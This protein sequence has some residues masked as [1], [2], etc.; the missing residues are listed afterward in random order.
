MLKNYLKIAW[1]N[2]T[3][4]K[5]FSFINIFGLASGMT[6]CMLAM[7]KV[8]DAYDYDTF[9][10]NSEKSY[11][12]ITNLNRK[13]GEH[14]LCASSPLPLAGYLKNNY[15]AVDKSTS[16]FFSQHEVTIDDKKLSAKEAFVD[17][18]FY[19][20]FGFTLK[21]GSPA[22]KPQTAVVT[23][24]T[25]ARF[26]GKQ[27]PIGH[28]ITIGK[29]VGFIVTGVL[30]KP[31]GPSHLSFDLLA[32]TSSIPLLYQDRANQEWSDEAAAYTYIQ[33]KPTAS[34]TMLQNILKNVSKQV[35]TIIVPSGENFEFDIQAL[36]K[37]S[38]GTIPL[39]N[40]TGE[41][42][43]P[44][45]V[46][47]GLIGFSMLLLAF[48]NYVNLTLARSL[49]RAREVGIRKVAGALKRD[50]I[51]QFLSESVLVAIFA[52]CLAYVQL[53]LIS[54]LPTVNRIIGDAAQDTTL[55]LYFVLFTILTGLFAGWIPAKVLS[56]FQPVRVLKGKFN[57]KLFGGVGLRKTLTVIQFATSLVA[58]VTLV[59]FYRQSIYMATADYGFKRQGILNIELPA[60]TYEKTATAF[61]ALSGVEDVSATSDLPGFSGGDGKFIK[62]GKVGDSLRAAYFAVT[63]SFIKNM[64]IELIA[65]E[66]LPNATSETGTDLVL[67]NEQAVN[68]LKF[69]TPF[70]AVGKR[71]WLNDSTSY[72]V[73]GVV[74]D[75]H[76]ASFKRPI[77]PMLLVSRPNEF[78]TMCLKVAKG[79]EGTIIPNLEKAWKKLYPNQPFKADWFDKQLYDQ[80]LH[81][82][83]LVFIGLLTFM[84]LSIAC[85]GLLGMVIYTTK[86][87]EKEVGIR[88]VMGAKVMQVI[89]TISKEF[90]VLLL[91]SVCIGLPIGFIAG[92][93]FLQ[94]YA[95]R[96]PVN[97]WLLAASA[98]GLLLLGALT[99]GWQTY[100]TALTNPAK[101]LRTE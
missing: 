54:S 45:L 62:P 40:V 55:W 4:H 84:A 22:T 67:I 20:I 94:Q 38:P 28:T 83:D 81:K 44:N 65:G 32:S 6:V 87:R 46:I 26:F 21:S 47:F 60:N 14:F 82:D 3:K 79:A 15:N 30:S 86:N 101:S 96:I 9:H 78:R 17:A 48:F 51:I 72:T 1:R 5:L 99:I 58:I 64:G 31:A 24:E 73:A 71:I 75:F 10:P 8:K 35:N 63:P 92:K 68:S 27:N 61:S 77:N 33:L 11:R 93:Q 98:T 97:F 57:T 18:D 2:L 29:S 100:R 89:V 12:I 36:D 41:P 16:V 70:E 7:I 19:N 95:Y 37:I 34:K 74:K 52:F 49:D 23:A 90:I 42:I 85:L 80:H 91:I 59:I 43:L 56:S 25:A 13:N 88:R 50:L 76:Y 53:R 39:Y 69:K 66:N